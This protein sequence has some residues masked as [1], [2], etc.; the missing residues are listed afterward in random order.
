MIT[1]NTSGDALRTVSGILDFDT[2]R[3]LLRKHKTHA[4]QHN[5][6]KLDI[7]L[8]QVTHCS[9]CALGKP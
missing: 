4:Q 9:S 8:S 1:L 5:I 3:D 2:S 6:R 7:H